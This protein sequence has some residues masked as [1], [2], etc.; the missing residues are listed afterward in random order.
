MWFHLPIQTLHLYSGLN[1][2]EV[3]VKVAENPAFTAVLKVFNNRFV[4]HLN[5]HQC[6]LAVN[7]MDH[8]R[9]NKQ[10]F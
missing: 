5:F 4:I 1:T 3:A 7:F 6:N 2:D 9:A 10:S 8:F